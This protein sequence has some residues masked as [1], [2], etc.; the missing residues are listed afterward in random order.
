MF[1]LASQLI[2]V[3]IANVTNDKWIKAEISQL[4]IDLSNLTSLTEEIRSDVEDMKINEQKF[5][6]KVLNEIGELKNRTQS[7]NLA[8]STLCEDKRTW[9]KHADCSLKSIRINCPR[10]CNTCQIRK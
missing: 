3:E 9:C 1:K 5:Q 6:K 4:A 7:Y 8:Q 2:F 10:S